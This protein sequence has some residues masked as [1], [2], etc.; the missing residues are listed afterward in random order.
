MVARSLWLRAVIAFTL[1]IGFYAVALSVGLGLLGGAWLIV[2]QSPRIPIKLVLLMVFAGGVVLWSLIPR[3]SKWVAPGPVITEAEQPRLFA[4]IREV[5]TQMNQPMPQEVYL[6]PDVNAFVANVG[7]FLGLGGRRVMGVGLGLLAVDNV[8]Q[9]RATIAHEFGH[10]AGGDTKV[11]GLV[12]ATRGVMIRT[13]Q[14]L[15]NA[16]SILAKPFEWLFTLYLRITQAISRQQELLA[17][18]WSVR[19]AGK[20]AHVTGLRQEA[21]HGSSFGLFVQHE[22]QPLATFG[23]APRNVFEGFRKFSGS[24]A[25][26][27]LEP[28]LQKAL[29]ESK[30]DVYDSHPPLEERVA[31]AHALQLPDLPMDTRVGTTLLEK[32]DELEAHFSQN[33]IGAGLE[34]IDWSEAGKTL[35]RSLGPRAARVQVR[36]PGMTVQRGLDVLA[37]RERPD[38]FAELVDP[39]LVAWRMPDRTQLVEGAL[40]SA[41]EA[42]FGVLL[43]ERGYEWHTSPGE[44]LELRRGEQRVL[45]REL[46]ADIL[47]RKRAPSEVEELLEGA[48]IERTATVPVDEQLR[49]AVLEPNAEVTVEPGKKRTVVR[50]Q[51]QPLLLPRCCAL[52]QGPAVHLVPTR[53]AIGGLIKSSEQWVELQVP[54]C[55]EHRKKT[56]KAL[57]VKAYDGKQDRVT[58]EVDDASYAELIQKVNA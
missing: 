8:S 31:Y 23:V 20:T 58:F 26:R 41:L 47:Q 55:E 9:V 49:R 18:E 33:V 22:V 40:V 1:L 37:G 3:F 16:G 52:C 54:A 15:A 50:A 42:Y 14:N 57:N 19:I 56:G 11:G 30:G 25:F 39:H 7:G 43:A 46:L 4:L 45:L 5:A 53:F 36:V 34:V 35:A 13:L 12:Y 17:D 21:L 27:K 10:F 32:A 44:P 29:S 51:L 2:T 48:G 38:A 6:I 28:V 24:S